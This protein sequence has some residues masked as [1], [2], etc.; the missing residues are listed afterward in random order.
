MAYVRTFS[1]PNEERIPT[2]REKMEAGNYLVNIS[3]TV[4]HE[5]F[6]G[7]EKELSSL[8]TQLIG[9]ME[10]WGVGVM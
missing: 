5:T 1:R 10:C 3:L 4:E 2:R 7:D 8:R 9:K 6:L